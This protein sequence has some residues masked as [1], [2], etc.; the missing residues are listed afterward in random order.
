[1]EI[2]KP[3]RLGVLQRPYRW[4]QRHRLSLSVVALATLDKPPV[5]LPEQELWALLDEALDE[6]DLFDLTMPKPSA[7]FLVTGYAYT[8]HSADKTVCAVQ[9]RV[10]NR[11]KRLMVFGDRYWVEGR[12]T[13]PAEFDAMPLGRRQAY[14][15]P[16]YAQNPIGIG[17]APERINELNVQ[18]LPNIEHALQQ[19]L[20]PSQQP[21][22]PAGFGMLDITAPSHMAKLGQYDQQWLE[23]DCPGFP[24]SFDWH[25]FNV[26]PQ[27][28]QWLDRDRIPCGVDYEFLNMHPELA[29]L[30]GRLPDGLARCFVTRHLPGE[31]PRFEEVPLRFTTAW[32]FPHAQCA[33]LIHHGDLAVADEQASDILQLMPAFEASDVPRESAH[34]AAV[35]AQRSDADDGDLYVFDEAALISESFISAGFDTDS[36]ESEPPGPMMRNLMQRHQQTMQDERER[37][38]S[39]GLDPDKVAGFPSGEDD[40]DD[41]RLH[42]L[43]DLP[44]FEAR[45]RRKEAELK[46]KAE[47][48]RANLLETLRKQESTAA[49]RALLAQL[50]NVNEVP[51]FDFAARSSQLQAAYDPALFSAPLDGR[52]APPPKEETDR[53]L[54][55][56]Y[57]D[58][59]QFCKPAPTLTGAEAEVLRD[60]VAARYA[61]DRDLS[62]MDLT[63]AD[64][65]DM[66]LTG[67]RLAGALL[68]SANLARTRLDGADLTEAILARTQLEGTS[69]RGANCRGANLSHAVARDTCFADTEFSDGEWWEVH[70]DACDFSRARFA[71]MMWQECT[72]TSC[73][74][75]SAALDDVSFYSC[76]LTQPLFTDATLYATTW[77]ES[78]L[79]VAN[80][81][82][83]ELDNCSLVDTDALRIRFVQ[84]VLSACYIVLESD[85]SESD[86]TA[87]RL[88]ET[89]LRAT[90]LSGASFLEAR[91]MDCDLSE[92]QLRG[93]NLRKAAATGCL[94]AGADLGAAQLEGAN[95]MRAMLRRADLRAADLHGVSLF[96]S[97]LAE[98][99]LDAA[100]VL[101]DANTGRA[102]VHPRRRPEDSTP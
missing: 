98:V 61:L 41:L 72:L 100:T 50:E 17:H 102:N 5:L 101:D 13:P 83:A 48:E 56:L 71:R 53:Q 86:F 55:Q 84:A 73:C 74:F 2:I 47:A 70:L 20:S 49:T 35:L 99:H 90:R 4:Q 45:L 36:L 60:K 77:V 40:M 27:D 42:R 67:A 39:V 34:Y 58:S 33:A 29:S 38:R 31:E 91:L 57:R 62:E 81:E 9:A 37:M 95:L 68:E 64:L 96:E 93:A 18:R 32:F 43:A 69:L 82:R 52:V 65:S 15:G 79:E 25:Y 16:D 59:V 30:A 22:M 92:A 63:G 10:D 19:L 66:D 28:Q 80:F 97:D 54:R 14:G 8:H 94:F 11:Q 6:D 88:V 23:R 87:A 7:E 46:A 85:L 89:N 76:L 44:Q 3:L 51:P 24:E 12:A 78:I 26:A 75:D 21:D 1:M